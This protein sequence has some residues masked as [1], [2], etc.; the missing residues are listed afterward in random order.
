MITD[1]EIYDEV[2]KK[3]P[4]DCF[5]FAM[6]DCCHSGTNMDLPY[7]ACS[8]YDRDSLWQLVGEEY[9]NYLRARKH[10]VDFHP[11]L[12]ESCG[13]VVALAGTSDAGKS[14]EVLEHRASLISVTSPFSK[15]GIGRT[16]S[17]GLTTEYFVKTIREHANKLETLTYA[18]LMK[19]VNTKLR[20]F[21]E[22]NKLFS[23]QAPALS[24][25]LYFNLDSP[26]RL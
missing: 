23:D 3:V 25:S 1:D 26:F 11:A 24:A 9:Y 16:G 21:L 13:I 14:L 4:K 2:V 8:Q 15:H 19:G 12:D 20:Q 6:F 7:V 18:G 10:K 17:K 22:T 5:L